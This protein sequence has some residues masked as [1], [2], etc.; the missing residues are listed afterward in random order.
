MDLKEM[1]QVFLINLLPFLSIVY[2]VAGI[3]YLRHKQSS[4]MN[5]IGLFMFASAVYS[6]GYFLE[7]QTYDPQLL[8]WIRGFEFFG[9]VALPGL[10]IMYIAEYALGQMLSRKYAVWM[11]VLS[12]ALWIAFV[13]NPLHHLFYRS[14]NIVQGEIGTIVQTVKGP[15]DY[16]LLT[17]YCCFI[18]LSIYFLASAIFRA[19]LPDKAN[20]K[21]ILLA[22]FFVSWIPLIIILS[23]Y[24]NNVDPIPFALVIMNGI[25][26]ANAV[27]NRVKETGTIGKEY[28][29]LVV[30]MQQ[31]LAIHEI[32]C[33]QFGKP[34]DYRFL[35][36][37]D[38][39]E[40]L[41]GLKRKDIIGKTVLQVM[42]NTEQYWIQIYGDVAL[43][44]KP[45]HYTNY[46]SELDR[47]YDVYAYSPK[48]RHFAVLF[49]DITEY[50][51]MEH[52][53]YLE[54]EM[55]RTTVM[56]V[57][58]GIISTDAA[59]KVKFMN[60]KAE[61]LTGYR[62]EAVA[63][64]ELE[65][66]I[67]LIDSI[68][69][70]RWLNPAEPVYA[71]QQTV[72]FDSQKIL[73]SHSGQEIPVEGTISPI[74]SEAGSTVGAVLIF[75]D[76]TEKKKK[77]DEILFLSYHD[78]LTG[79]YNRR[80]F[81]E[82][83]KRL[84][85]DRNLPMTLV[86][87]DV[88]GLK[89]INDAFGHQTADQVLQTVAWALRRECRSDDIIARIGGDEFVLLL[90]KTEWDLA[91]VISNRIQQSIKNEKVQALQLSV[92]YG[93]ETKREPGTEMSEIFKNAENNMYVHKLVESANTRH[94]IVDVI[95]KTLHE[96]NSHEEQH[97][98]HV[99][100][101]CAKLAEQ[102]KLSRQQVD[103]LQ[104]LGWMHDI[105]KISVRQETLHK[106]TP[107]TP[108]EW[109]EIK[110]H[111]EIGFKILSSTN[112]YIQMAE[113][114]LHQHERW[115]GTGYPKG[116]RGSEISIQ[117]R[118]M[119]VADAYD[120]MTSDRIYGKTMTHQEAL[121][122]LRRFSGIQFD[123]AVVAAFGTLELDQND[124][125]D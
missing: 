105:G 103:E 124:Q 28:E 15:G 67:Y 21:K 23:G 4:R 85:T 42:P 41:T 51:G 37:N 116:L 108:P 56:S 120:T 65:Q 13:T 44:G 102:M 86:M 20:D 94:G 101:L 75:R 63:G 84:D 118:I 60:E 77:Q 112:E 40:K 33:N 119:A 5:Y 45:F 12:A 115:D 93:W 92:S 53:L 117:S 66:V 114:V 29:Q 35:S 16:L 98:K 81:E 69:R 91:E 2:A 99:S 76:N 62:Q 125:T 58:D 46:S 74:I 109:T 25:F 14:I 36:I 59:G 17:Y 107:L 54:K 6:F 122:E 47:Y 31:G 8:L 34:Y 10:G 95:M 30:Q 19:Q 43:T 18:V 3:R 83:L 9:V 57:A 27:M 90:P 71:S 26:L 100:K 89:L 80:F 73:M 22:A 72:S 55:F 82:E 97:A 39:F 49:S 7:I 123:P 24:D 70:E 64:K 1:L 111:S 96:K 61:L 106:E 78:Q 88:N 11:G 79:L 68:S 104:T 121:A 52:N 113:H 32:I 110:R 48:P 38:S 87:F 50:K